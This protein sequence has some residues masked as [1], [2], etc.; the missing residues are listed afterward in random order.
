MMHEYLHIEQSLGLNGQASLFGA[1]NAVLV[2]MASTL[3]TNGK[4]RFTNVPRS[5]DVYQMMRLLTSLGAA[6]SF[7]EEVHILEIDTSFV[8]KFSVSAD[9][10]GKMRASVLVMGPLLARFGQAQVTLPGGCVIG[11]RPIDYHLKNFERMGVFIES[12]Q[13]VVCAKVAALRPTK[14]VFDYPSVGATENIL[15][16][17]TLT[18]GITR[19][20]H[21]ALEPEV[22]DLIAVLKKM[23]AKITIMPPATIEIE[24]V[25]QLYPV[26]HEIMPDRL[27]A[28]ALLLAAAITGGQVHIPQAPA[29]AME[30]FLSKLQDMGHVIQVGPL[31]VG[32]TLKATTD[33]K[34]V[35][36]KTTPYPGFPTDLQAPM[37]A[38]QCLA[39]GT[40][41]IEE[42]VFENR[43]V[44]VRE[45]QKMGAQIVVKHN[46]AHVTGVDELYGAQ[47]IASDIRASCALVLAGLAST[48][49]TIMS[50]VHH[51]RRGYDALEQKLGLLGARIAYHYE[52]SPKNTIDPL[53][54][55]AKQSHLHHV[56]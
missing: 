19:I 27:E 37:M 20:V 30:I 39:S 5:H 40:S 51:W 18:Q 9:L 31:D 47:V 55:S 10:M 14:L 45:L 16:L 26:E 7:D 49:I 15:M 23:G 21:A 17:A 38:A 36:F 35:S 50:A 28:G 46:V 42:T 54:S 48:G 52:E 22:L 2:I 34:A 3:L 41:I 56:S 6:V 33:P 32:I 24:G 43:L 1:K 53:L 25:N 13:E 11:A 44:H 8:N 4:S 29:Y 12:I